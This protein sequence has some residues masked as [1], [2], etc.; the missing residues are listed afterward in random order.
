MCDGG[1]LLVLRAFAIPQSKWDTRCALIFASRSHTP[2]EHVQTGGRGSR[3]QLGVADYGKLRAPNATADDTSFPSMIEVVKFQFQTRASHLEVCL[4]FSL[5]KF[6]EIFGNMECKNGKIRSLT[7]F[8]QTDYAWVFYLKETAGFNFSALFKIFG[9]IFQ[10]SVTQLFQYLRPTVLNELK[11]K[12]SQLMITKHS[13]I[14]N[15]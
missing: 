4:Y 2:V 1:G 14:S 7:R 12:T 6:S 5:L 9:E 3:A 13:R 15:F 10:P 11:K 8:F